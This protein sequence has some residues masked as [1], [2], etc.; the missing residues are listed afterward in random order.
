MVDTNNLP[1]SNNCN[2]EMY[3]CIESFAKKE[4][5]QRSKR[6]TTYFIFSSLF[7]QSSHIT[8]RQF[9]FCVQIFAKFVKEVPKQLKLL[10]NSLK[11]K[12][13]S[14]ALFIGFESLLKTPMLRWNVIIPCFVLIR[15]RAMKFVILLLL[16]TSAL[17]SGFAIAKPRWLIKGEQDGFSI[18][19]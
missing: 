5:S 19:Q 17:F 3:F 10:Y 2:F 6:A 13:L 7:S 11:T 14:L 12:S 4:M 18:N 16:C 9:I 1:L 15:I 8:N